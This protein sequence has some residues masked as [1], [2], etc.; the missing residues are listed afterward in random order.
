[1]NDS[2]ENFIYASFISVGYV[3]LKTRWWSFWNLFI[4]CIL[5]IKINLASAKVRNWFWTIFKSKVNVTNQLL[6]LFTI[7]TWCQEKSVYVKGSS[8][9]SLRRYIWIVLLF[10]FR[11]IWVSFELL[12]WKYY[13]KSW[14]HIMKHL[15]SQHFTW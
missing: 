3:L 6:L 4:V 11:N 10:S 1:M 2:V 8:C 9:R 5:L 13:I 14:K 12:L 15:L 7:L